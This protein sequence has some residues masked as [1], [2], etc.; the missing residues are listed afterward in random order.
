M[1]HYG[2]LGHV[3]FVQRLAHDARFRWFLNRGN[4]EGI[5]GRDMLAKDRRLFDANHVALRAK[6]AGLFDARYFAVETTRLKEWGNG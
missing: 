3:A 2:I 6:G 5:F 4:A 1:A